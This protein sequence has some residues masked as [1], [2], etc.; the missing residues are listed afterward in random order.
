[1]VT[2]IMEVNNGMY[3]SQ[4]L[5]ENVLGNELKY[6]NLDIPNLGDKCEDS[7]KKYLIHFTLKDEYLGRRR[8]RTNY[9]VPSQGVSILLGSV[10]G[11]YHIKTQ[12]P[13]ERPIT[14]EDTLE[15]VRAKIVDKPNT[16]KTYKI[17]ITIDWIADAENYSIFYRNDI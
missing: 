13:P 11:H 12:E 7:V 5:F 8:P 17:R 2:N 16:Y 10:K 3:G 14:K 4:E 6:L 1:M 9:K 15:E